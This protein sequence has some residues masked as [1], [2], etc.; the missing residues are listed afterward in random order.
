[1]NLQELK[2]KTILLFGKSR[3]FATSEFDL[4]MQYHKID[5]VK[6][7]QENIE[8]IV[9]GRMMTPYEQNTSE[10]LY[11]EKKATFISID[12]L[13][14]ALAQSIDEDTL[15]MSLKLSHDKTRLKAFLLNSMI[16]DRLFFRLMK[17][18]FWSDEDFFENDDNRDVSAAF[19]NR[20]YENIERNHN[21]QFATTGFI[22][23]VAQTQ[24]AELLKVISTL[25]PLKFHPKIKIAIAMSIYLSHG[26]QKQFFKLKD[27]TI[28]E[29]LSHNA[30]LS[31]ELAKEFLESQKFVN[32]IAVNINLNDEVFELLQDN[33]IPLAQNTSLTLE[34]QKRLLENPLRDV[35]CSLALNDNLDESITKK[36]LALND[37]EIEVAIYENSSTSQSILKEAYEDE[38]NHIYLA[39]NENTPI[40]ILYQL[41]LDARY[42]R[43]VKTNAGFGKH[44]QTENIGWL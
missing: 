3:A 7:Y 34:M 42:D 29:A 1:M 23:L 11:E 4:Q 2:N 17:M 16:S 41:Q 25:A 20:F 30:N 32:N 24:D 14:S 26:M 19:I 8:F 35:H 40:D 18:Y 43:H 27:E 15:L 6:E 13:E 36:L 12:E 38:K 37:R 5:I 22:H 9:D 39:K 31:I 10:A 44:I 28:L 21:V 33:L